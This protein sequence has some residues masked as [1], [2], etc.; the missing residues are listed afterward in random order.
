[1]IYKK[2]KDKISKISKIK[3]NLLEKRKNNEKQY[4]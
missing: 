2:V 4:H 3:G 1:M